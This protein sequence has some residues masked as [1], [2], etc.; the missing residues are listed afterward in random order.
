[1]I[2][3][4]NI[5][6]EQQEEILRKNADILL[7]KKQISIPNE[8]M[9]QNKKRIEAIANNADQFYAFFPNKKSEE[10]K[11]KDQSEIPTQPVAD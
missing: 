8:V 7:E 9:V 1:M 2:Q 4:Y 5:K 3:E 6:R 10:S 11:V